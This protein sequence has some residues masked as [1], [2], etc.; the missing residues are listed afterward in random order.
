MTHLPRFMLNGEIS[1]PILRH[2]TVPSAQEAADASATRP[3]TSWLSRIAP[4][5]A[6]F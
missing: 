2:S 4:A 5:A 1:S 3:K 6:R